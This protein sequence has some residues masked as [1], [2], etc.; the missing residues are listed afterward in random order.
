MWVSV[1]AQVVKALSQDMQVTVDNLMV[2]QS[3]HIVFSLV[4]LCNSI[5]NESLLK[6][7]CG[8]GQILEDLNVQN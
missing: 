6:G 7:K 3:S 5:D 4:D 8:Q 2:I 1:S